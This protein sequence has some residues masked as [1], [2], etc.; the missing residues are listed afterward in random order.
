M[1]C[2]ANMEHKIKIKESIDFRENGRVVSRRKKFN[3]NKKTKKAHTELSMKTK[4]G[5][6]EYNG[7]SSRIY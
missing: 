5:K 2:A 1:L 4:G 3:K 6:S 7:I